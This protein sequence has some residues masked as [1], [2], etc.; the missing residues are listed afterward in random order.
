VGAED[1]NLTGPYYW[2]PFPSGWEVVAK[3]DPGF[4]VKMWSKVLAMLGEAYG[5]PTTGLE[6]AYM[7]LPRGRVSTKGSGVRSVFLISH[8]GERPGT[9]AIAREFGLPREKVQEQISEHE[10]MMQAH[11]RQF[12]DV[13]GPKLSPNVKQFLERLVGVQSMQPAASLRQ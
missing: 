11:T 1:E 7:A 12:L 10:G 8:G 9:P 4:H 13:L 5:V 3:M 2:V 6:G